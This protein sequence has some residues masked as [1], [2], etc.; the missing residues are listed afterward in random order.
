[1]HNNNRWTPLNSFTIS[2][3]VELE[4]LALN[5]SI[6]N[7]RRNDALRSCSKRSK[8]LAQR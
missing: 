2:K 7:G 3:H 4:R 5:G 1:M 8:I 6:R